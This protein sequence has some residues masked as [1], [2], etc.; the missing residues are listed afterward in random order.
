MGRFA[1]RSLAFAL[2]ILFSSSGGSCDAPAP[3]V[4]NRPPRPVVP[5]P[6]VSPSGGANSN[7]SPPAPMPSPQGTAS[8]PGVCKNIPGVIDLQ[9]CPFSLSG[10]KDAEYNYHDPKALES[11]VNRVTNYIEGAQAV[12][13]CR[14][15]SVTIWGFADNRNLIKVLP[16]AEVPQYCQQE[17]RRNGSEAVNLTNA[18]LACVRQC[19]I[20]NRIKSLL[21][22]NTQIYDNTSQRWNTNHRPFTER[23]EVGKEYR[24]VDINLER[25]G[26][27]LND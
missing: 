6:D 16:W 5:T 3:Q 23:T 19:L 18:D 9:V 4:N 26:H 27:C 25:G 7:T 1:Y 15:V 13:G 20:A 22:Y 24:R 11:F 2:A 10:Y 14:L 8:E 21:R 12:E 17:C